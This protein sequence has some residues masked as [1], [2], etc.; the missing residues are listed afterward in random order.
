M[1]SI[2]VGGLA[3]PANFGRYSFSVFGTRVH[4]LDTWSHIEQDLPAGH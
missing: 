3:G 1:L 2:A 4:D